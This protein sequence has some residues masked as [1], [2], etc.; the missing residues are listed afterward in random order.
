MAQFS[1]EWLE[2]VKNASDILDVVGQ[3]VDLKP[4]GKNFTGLCPFHNE[5]TPSFSVNREKQFF[6]CFG[7]GAGGNVFNF[8]MRS[9]GLSFPEAAEDLAKKAGIPVPQRSAAEEAKQREKDAIYRINHVAAEFFYRRLRRQ[10]GAEARTYLA[11]RHIGREASRQFFLGYAPNSWDELTDYLWEKGFSKELLVR[12]G[13][14]VAGTKGLYDRFRGRIIFPICD[15]QGRFLGFGGRTLGSGSPKYLNTPETPAFQKSYALYGLNWSKDYIKETETAVLVEGYTDCISLFLKGVRNT[16]A[17]LGTA[18]TRHHAQLL[19]RF[20]KEVILAYDGDTAGEKAA[21][22]GMEVL[23]EGGLVVKVAPLAAGVDPDGFA[24]AHAPDEVNDWIEQAVHHVE[25]RIGRTCDRHDLS[26]REGKVAA[27]REV[28]GIIS[29]LTDAVERNEYVEFAARRLGVDQAALAEEVSESR[30]GSVS[31]GRVDDSRDS[32]GVRRGSAAP[33]A[34]ISSVHEGGPVRPSAEQG[35]VVE[36][37]ILRC[38]LHKPQLLESLK[39]LGIGVK[40]F[41]HADYRHLYV[42]LKNGSWDLHGEKVADQLF[43]HA[44][45]KGKWREYIYRLVSL[46]FSR[47]LVKIEE[48]LNALEKNVDSPEVRNTFCQLIYGYFRVRKKVFDL[49]ERIREQGPLGRGESR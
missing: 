29:A 31:S 35:M 18:F 23:T 17:S 9:E 2:T 5:K 39:E 8:L 36:R 10:E 43:Q 42:L 22:R 49:R 38:V 26:T 15:H 34:G 7:C 32:R 47:E 14:A 44:V 6:Y 41:A 24:R 45:P 12:S 13:L 21:E 40:H 16:A 3:K 19:K 33:E 37:D 25:Y 27:S 20:A 1:D 28:V 11:Q 30:R 48:K 46:N 4:A